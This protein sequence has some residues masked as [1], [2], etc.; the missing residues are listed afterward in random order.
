MADVKHYR[1]QAKE[2]GLDWNAVQVTY[3]DL[4]AFQR[5]ER[6]ADW[7]VRK[8][9]F[10]LYARSEDEMR[11]WRYPERLFPRAFGEGDRTNIPGFDDAAKTIACEF[12]EFDCDDPAERLFEFLQTEWVRV[13]SADETYEEAIQLCLE[14]P[15]DDPAIAFEFG[16]NAV[17]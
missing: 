4:R 5:V 7:A 12:P 10:E 3:R 16:A 11:W 9:F 13:P 1:R 17:F 15:A 14:S 8:R 2:L 6:E